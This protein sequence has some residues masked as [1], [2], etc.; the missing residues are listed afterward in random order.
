MRTTMKPT[1]IPRR[2]ALG[3]AVMLAGLG[4]AWFHRARAERGLPGDGRAIRPPG[5]VAEDEFLAACVRCGL[6]VQ[7][8][9]WQTLQLA[10]TDG[11]VAAG[12]PYFRAREVPCEMCD[13]IPCQRA[14]PTGALVPTLARIADSRMGLARLSRPEGCYS[15]IGAA[16]CDSCWGA[17]PLQG[18]AITMQRGRTRLGGFFTPTVDDAVCTGCGKCEKACIAE[19]P[20]IT[21]T[22]SRDGQP[23]PRRA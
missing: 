14:C 15:F 22:A 18:R 10:A 11:P 3:T 7:A 20:A 8:C 4:A 23:K 1:S 2:R 6:C 19:E 21:V 12:T 16:K 13:D 5:A 17:C 9:P